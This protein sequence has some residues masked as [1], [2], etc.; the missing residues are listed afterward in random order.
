[1]R[2]GGRRWKGDGRSDDVIRLLIGSRR[3]GRPSLIIVVVVVMVVV[4]VSGC[5]QWLKRRGDCNNWRGYYRPGVHFWKRRCEVA[6]VVV[7]HYCAPSFCAGALPKDEV[8][9]VLRPPFSFAP[10]KKWI[11]LNSQEERGNG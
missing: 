2:G 10:E 9:V 5:E 7:T 3:N 11:L 1:M 8:W 6:C 4:L